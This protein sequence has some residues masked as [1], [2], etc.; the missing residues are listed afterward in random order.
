MCFV[1][2]GEVDQL[3]QHGLSYPY[4]PESAPGTSSAVAAESRSRGRREAGS[5]RQVQGAAKT[6]LA[7]GLASA[8]SCGLVGAAGFA[9]DRRGAGISAFL[10]GFIR[11]MSDVP[12]PKPGE[13]T[14]A[15]AEPPAVVPRGTASNY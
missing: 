10:S 8:C 12:T 3:D 14:V 7:S 13:A 11:A 4:S 15:A 5:S 2:T 6:G 1:R 9:A